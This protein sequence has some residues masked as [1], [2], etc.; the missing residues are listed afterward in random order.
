MFL[1]LGACSQP[2]LKACGAGFDHFPFCNHSLPLDQ[3][4]WDLVSRIDDSVKPNLLT[5]RG[6]RMHTGGRQALPKLGVPSYYWGSNCLHSSMFANCTTDGRCS[7]SFPSNTAWAATFDRRLMR[8]MAAVVGRET[9]AGWNLG[10]WLDDGLNGAGLDCW[11]PVLNMNR[12]PRWGRNGEGGA[13]D[14]YLMGQLGTAWT[15]G[16]QQGDP[17]IARE[18]ASQYTLVAVT[19]KHFDANSLEDSDGFTRHTVDV[20]V[21][22][23]LLTD[24]YWPAF[25]APIR[26]AGALGVMCSYNAVNGLPACASPVMKAAREA[27]GFQ[28]YVTSD[29]DSVADVWRA[30]RYKRTAEEASCVALREGGTDVDSGNTY[31]HSLLS[32]VRSGRCSISDV[33]R[34]LFNTFRVRFKLGLFDPKAGNPY[35]QLGEA[36]IGTAA[37]RALNRHAAAASLVLLQN[38]TS[39]RG[40]GPILPLA[41]GKR[42]AVLGPHANATRALIQVDTGKVCASGG[43]ECVTSP[44]AALADRNPDAGTAYA[45]GCDVI[46]MGRQGFSAA[47]AAAEAAEVVVLGL[48]GTSCGSW[49]AGRWG[50]RDNAPR[51]LHCRPANATNGMQWAEGE[52]HDRTSIDLPG[53]QHALAAAVLA[54]NK[55]TVLFLLNGGMVSVAEELRHAINPP[56]VVEAFYPGAEGGEALAD[57]LFGRT[58]RWG[59]M[60]YSVYTADWAKTNSML[61][62]DVQ[63]GLGRTYRYYR[64]SVPLVTP[65]GHGLSYTTFELAIGEPRG[66]W[67]LSTASA[68]ALHVSVVLTNVGPREGDEAYF[69][70]L[71]LA[72]PGVP[73]HPI[74]A[75]W[76]F[77]R[78]S[79][80]GSGESA[81]VTF[82]LGARDLQLSDLNGDLVLAPGK[83]N[84]T[85]E[86]G[87]G[88]VAA[89]TVTLTGERRN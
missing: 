28:G 80:L 42:I 15:R 83:Y 17:E 37:S 38:P 77:E 36:D 55:P 89:R 46:L 70:P 1:A 20:N 68:T 56:A 41:P 23:Q 60:P 79:D 48:G 71:S 73:N 59:K 35:W 32:G 69:A 62:H 85:F 47:L 39:R 50:K 40:G 78:V 11:G 13:E 44:L 4:V 24:Y 30:H 84:V 3:R 74:K 66:G 9:R 64:G 5:A 82:S 2:G 58:N 19:L 29:T 65:F 53:E 88:A 8:Q 10:S 34:A 33:D 57:A 21:S 26:E 49:G 7:Q 52:A 75:L 16:L 18:A 87:A 43:F 63:H 12:D 25:R 86:N 27:W 14:P 31:Y 6:H 54:L 81:T 76:G 67:T 45:E 61:D 72:A 51:H 22:R